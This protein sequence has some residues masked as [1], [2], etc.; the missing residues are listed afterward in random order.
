MF[1]DKSGKILKNIITKTE[2][3]KDNI[4]TWSISIKINTIWALKCGHSVLSK[5]QIGKWLSEDF[6]K[7]WELIVAIKP[8]RYLSTFFPTTKPHIS[9]IFLKTVCKK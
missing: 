3:K 2:I 9:G 5:W 6:L 7:K 4:T 8:Q 1:A